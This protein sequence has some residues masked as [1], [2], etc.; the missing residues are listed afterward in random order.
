MRHYLFSILLFLSL[1][2]KAQNNNML[3][4]IAFE[5]AE[6]ALNA[7]NTEEA[8]SELHLVD[9][10]LNTLTPKSQYLRVQIWAAA[11]E[12]NISY[13]DSVI[14]ESKSYLA[15]SKIH[16]LPEDK[17]MDVTRLIV[18]LEKDKKVSE[19]KI[20]ERKRIGFVVDSLFEAYKVKLGSTEEEFRLY[21]PNAFNGLTRYR[22]KNASDRFYTNENKLTTG[23]EAI[24][25]NNGRVQWFNYRLYVGNNAD[26][27]KKLFY[28]YKDLFPKNL[29]SDYAAFGNTISNDREVE[30]ITI[31]GTPKDGSWV[32]SVEGTWS[33]LIHYSKIKN[34]TSTV[35]LLFFRQ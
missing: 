27:A 32:H 9:K 7:G 25:F 13:A 10:Y 19:E 14:R 20:Y 12:K 6:V 21:N 31:S 8:L 26:E 29:K 16:D 35:F 24:M 17:V 22:K 18:K 1:H 30:T 5:N 28:I 2:S 15:L 4:K 33:V 23:P 11:T 3:A 34:T